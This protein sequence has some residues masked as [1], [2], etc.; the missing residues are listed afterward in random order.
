MEIPIFDS[1]I[2]KGDLKLSGSHA[3]KDNRQN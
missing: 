2:N 3:L 1:V